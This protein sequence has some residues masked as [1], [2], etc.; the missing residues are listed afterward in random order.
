MRQRKYHS[1]SSIMKFIDRREE[2]YLQYLAPVKV[3]KIPQTRPMAV[4]SAVDAYIKNYLQWNLFKNYG[5]DDRFALEKILT[6]QVEPHNLDWARKHGMLLFEGYKRSGLLAD[7][8]RMMEH[9]VEDPEMEFTVQKEV[10]GIILLG[11]PDLIWRTAN[12]IV[13]LDW[14]CNGYCSKNPVVPTPGYYIVRD[15][16]E[17]KRSRSH[18]TRHKDCFSVIVDGVPVNTASTFSGIWGQQLCMYAWLMGV[19]VG[20]DFIGAI[21]QFCGMGDQVRFRIA[22]HRA[23]VSANFQEDWM[24]QIKYIVGLIQTGHIFD[25]LSREESDARCQ[26]LDNYYKAFSDGND[27][28]RDIT[29]S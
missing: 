10:E 21:D 6:K 22:Q 14:K 20:G 18:N 12:E 5:K 15:G 27:V 19:P 17:G 4:G 7:V 1:H 23:R 16:W 29:R 2:A 13:I 28:F 24:S 9:A 25:E 8:V 3:E 11:K 26:T